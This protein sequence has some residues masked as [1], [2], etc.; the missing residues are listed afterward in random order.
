M[1]E[2]WSYVMEIEQAKK[3]AW[4]AAIEEAAKVIDQLNR[5]GPYNA[6]GGAKVI[7]KLKK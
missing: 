6:I 7:R 1:S 2:N 3:E 5:E 4:N